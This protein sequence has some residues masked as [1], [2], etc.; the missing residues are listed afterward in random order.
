MEGFEKEESTVLAK[1]LTKECPV[2][3]GGDEEIIESVVTGM[4]PSDMLELKLGDCNRAAKIRREALQRMTGRPLVGLPFGGFDYESLLGRCCEMPVGYVQI[5]VG[6]AGPLLLDGMEYFVPMAT[7]EACLVES[8]NRGFKAIFASG[9]AT[10]MLL[11]DGMTTTM[12]LRFGSAERASELQLF[13]EDPINFQ[14]LA[15]LFNSSSRFAMLQSIRCAIFGKPGMNLYVR[16]TCST[17]DA[18][19]MN[20]VVSKCVQR[21][22]DTLK[23][24][25]PDMDVVGIPGNFCSDMKPAAVNL[26]EGCGKSVLCQAIIKEEVVTKVLK[27]NV[28]ALVELNVL[29]NLNGST[30]AGTLGGFIAHTSN[31]VSA[32]FLA[33]GQDPAQILESS[34]WI[35]TMEVDINGKD[36]HISVNMPS[37]E[38]GTI[39]GGTQLASQSACL[40]LLGVKGG[41]KEL[42]GSNSRLLATIIAGSVLAGELSLMSAITAGQ[43]FNK[44]VSETAS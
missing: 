24:D 13:L 42:P 7:T 5:P 21:V 28:A 41:N 38:V 34:R 29:K 15:L 30:V 10:S 18:V 19:G 35:T 4:I 37:I 12:S 3:L 32:V 1:P 26:I 25:F 43:L 6:I 20:M 44:D 31:I 23:N 14:T 16:F 2:R 36:L 17:G 8:T 27:T 40:N 11:T 39:G 9:G 33:T 22:L